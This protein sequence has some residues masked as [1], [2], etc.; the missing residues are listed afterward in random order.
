MTDILSLT[1]VTL[2]GPDL[3][4]KTR[5]YYALHKMTNFK[6][7][8]QDRSEISMAIYA[9]MYGRPASQDWWEKVYAKL[10]DLTH[11]YV[12]LLPSLDLLIE[13]YHKRGDDVQNEKSLSNLHKR[14]VEA[15]SKLSKYPTCIVV[16]V[17]RENQSDVKN[18][19]LSH[20]ERIQASTTKN[21]ADEIFKVAASSA[22]KEMNG[23]RFVM[24]LTDFSKHDRSVLEYEKEKAYYKRIT[25]TYIKTIHDELS[26]D[27]EYG[28]P[29]DP[30]RSRR[31]VYC[32]PSCISY[33]NTQVRNKTM[34]MSV[35]C[36]SSDTENTIYY[37]VCFLQILAKNME[38]IFRK[39]CDIDRV[40]MKVRLDSAHVIEENK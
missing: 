3:S 12:V 8:I 15:A 13:R 33:I 40:I 24:N 37:D 29:Q 23:L 27:N 26:G 31:F 1:D 6:W 39:T 25:D 34:T 2:E 9:E 32:D 20:L 10:G 22:G 36:R 21:I 38:N 28:M 17:T 11:R 4:G 18:L 14:F 35:V 16:N 30:I 7:N 5:L 19:V